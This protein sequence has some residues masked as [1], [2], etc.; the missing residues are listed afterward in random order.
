MTD[1]KEIQHD[2]HVHI[3]CFVCGWAH[4]KG[5]DCEYACYGLEIV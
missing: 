2:D 5:L 1:T 4:V 3:H